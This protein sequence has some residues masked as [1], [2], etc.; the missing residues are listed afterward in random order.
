MGRS[1]S[2]LTTSQLRVFSPL[3]YPAWTEQ[4]GHIQPRE[5]YFERARRGNADVRRPSQTAKDDHRSR[6]SDASE[7][8]TDSPRA[9]CATER[10]G[11]DRPTRDNDAASDMAQ[12]LA[13]TKGQFER[14]ERRRSQAED[15]DEEMPPWRGRQGDDAL[16]DSATTGIGVKCA[17]ER[18]GP[19][20]PTREE[21][22]DEDMAR[23]PAESKEQFEMD[24]RRRRAL[25]DDS[26]DDDRKMPARGR[27]QGKGD[28]ARGGKVS[29]ASAVEIIALDDDSEDGGM[30]TQRGRQ[31]DHARGHGASEIWTRTLNTRRRRGCPWRMCR[32]RAGARRWGLASSAG[33]SSRTS[34]ARSRRRTAGSTPSRAGGWSGG[35]NRFVPKKEDAVVDGGGRRRT[36]KEG[37]YSA[38]YGR[39]AIGAMWR[40]FDVLEGRADMDVARGVNSCDSLASVEGRKEGKGRRLSGLP[41]AKIGSFVDIGHAIGVQVLQAGWTLNVPSRGVEIVEDRHLVSENFVREGALEALRRNPPDDSLIELKRADFSRAVRRDEARGLPDEGLRGFLLMRDR[42]EEVRRGLVAF[43]NNA[44]GVF[45]KRA[46][47]GADSP[48]LDQYLALLFANM[49]VGGRMV[50]L[51]D[52]S[53]HL[54]D[55]DWFCLD[56]FDSGEDA[57]S[58]VRASINVYVLTKLNDSWFCQDV[59]CP[60][61]NLPIAV[62]NDYG[63]LCDECHYCESQ[64]LRNRRSIAPSR[65]DRR[66]KEREA[67]AKTLAESLKMYKANETGS[68]KF[69]MKHMKAILLEVFDVNPGRSLKKGELSNELQRLVREQPGKINKAISQLESTV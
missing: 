2:L 68:R 27:W 50:T 5:S 60:G 65:R 44:R 57:V 37:Q 58:W 22:A 8:Q 39:F 48:S 9:E 59:K 46:Y 62:V 33:G 6:K 61:K 35:G 21:G 53:P 16:G 63:E 56:V 66:E 41:G 55:S 52:V 54:R 15:N 38:Q 49:E 17:A 40:T 1:L 7:D 42:D 34:S 3:I 23:A 69:T 43:S 32:T 18:D 45:E 24:E 51:T 28:D 12:T 25:G 67:R 47:E 29:D 30:P 19:G 64:S 14:D 36:Q 10:D 11:S 20:R 26:E 4:I 31:G 13:K